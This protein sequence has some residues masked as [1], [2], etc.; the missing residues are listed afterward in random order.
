MQLH[1]ENYTNTKNSIKL[2][3]LRIGFDSETFEYKERHSICAMIFACIALGRKEYQGK[4][5][6]ESCFVSLGN[7]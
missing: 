3:D 1:A 7:L 5:L 6:S 4:C 2:T